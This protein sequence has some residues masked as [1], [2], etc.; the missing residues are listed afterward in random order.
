MILRHA[1]AAMEK[2][3][4]FTWQ[5]LGALRTPTLTKCATKDMA[6]SFL[7][8]KMRRGGTAR[9]ERPRQSSTRMLKNLEEDR[10]E[11]EDRTESES[12]SDFGPLLGEL[13]KI[14]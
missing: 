3:F 5:L 12:E 11:E 2:K 10:M 7:K 6:V 8:A 4:S 1:K 9:E 13:L 14:D